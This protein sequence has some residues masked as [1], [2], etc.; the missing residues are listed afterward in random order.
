ML[1]MI[2]AFC[3]R[4]SIAVKKWAEFILFDNFTLGLA[5]KFR[6]QNKLHGF[7]YKKTT[8]APP[9]RIF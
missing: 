1:R 5:L 4:I 2:G 8:Y 3:F 7:I 6:K 9:G